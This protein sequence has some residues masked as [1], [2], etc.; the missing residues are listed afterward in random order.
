[1]YVARRMHT[2]L[3]IFYP[4]DHPDTCF[5]DNV[6]K[7]PNESGV[8]TSAWWWY[9]V[10][11]GALPCDRRF[12]PKQ[13]LVNSAVSPVDRIH[14]FENQSVEVGVSFYGH[15]RWSTCNCAFCSLNF[16][17]CA[18]KD[19]GF[20][21]RKITSVNIVNTPLNFICQSFF[22]F[23]L[24]KGHWEKKRV[25]DSDHQKEAGHLLCSKSRVK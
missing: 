17:L 7:Q 4:P 1:M 11:M 3:Y 21:T 13:W 8:G 6:M 5:P 15:C 2:S 18:V 23:F 19:T 24:P 10:R 12:I 20:Q 25:N 22:V 16:G 14:G 9:S